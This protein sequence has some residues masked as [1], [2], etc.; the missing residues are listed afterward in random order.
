MERFGPDARPLET[1]TGSIPSPI[2]SVGITPSAEHLRINEGWGTWSNGYDGDIYFSEAQTFT[3][4]LPEHTKAIYFYGEPEGFGPSAISATTSEGTTSGPV[5]V[6]GLGGAQ[7]FGFYTAGET[8]LESI[9][10]ATS[11]ASGFAIG[12]LGISAG[13]PVVSCE[14]PDSK[15]HPTNV[16]VACTAW[17]P[18][19]AGLAHPA[20]ETSFSLATTVGPG[21]ETSSAVTELRQICDAIGNCA[22]AGT[23]PHRSQGSRDQRR[24]TA[25]R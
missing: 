7:Y 16:S 13:A 1:K 19:G 5:G 11:D 23:V 6:V 10:V 18:G 21:E 12:E 25:G 2:G 15:W 24:R 17:D 4:S 20:T 3:L 22:Q 8:T 9:T 14:H